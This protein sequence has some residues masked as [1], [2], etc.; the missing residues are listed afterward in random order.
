MATNAVATAASSSATTGLRSLGASAPGDRTPTSLA[1]LAERVQHPIHLVRRV[2]MTEADAHRTARLEQSEADHDL[3]GVVVAVPDEDAAGSE[4]LRGFGRM[5]VAYSDRERGG[6]LT[7]AI[8]VG[9]APQR[10]EGRL[11]RPTRNRSASSRSC[12]SIAS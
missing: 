3:A 12:A 4:R 1:E 8:A 10:T 9:D 5:F 2:V 6:P 11:A 7:D